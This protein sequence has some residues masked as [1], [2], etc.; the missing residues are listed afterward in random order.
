MNYM[1][2]L[3]ILFK[4]NEGFIIQQ[5][6]D[7]GDGMQELGDPYKITHHRL[8]NITKAELIAELPKELTWVGSIPDSLMNKIKKASDDMA[9]IENGY[10]PEH[11]KKEELNKVTTSIFNQLSTISKNILEERAANEKHECLEEEEEDLSL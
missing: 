7:I 10:Q 3:N 4:I 2:K 1:D 9:R 5:S 8:T 6:G 11:F